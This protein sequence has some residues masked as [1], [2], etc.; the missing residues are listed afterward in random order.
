MSNFVVIVCNYNN[1]QFIEESLN[2][3]KNQS[4]TKWRAIIIDDFSS[5]NSVEI[6]NRSIKNDSRFLFLQNSLNIG[7]Q[8]SL[9]LALSFVNE[10][11]F[12]ARLDPDDTLDPEA[13]EISTKVHIE[14]PEVGLVYSDMFFCDEQLNVIDVH[15][16]KQIDSLDLNYYNFKGEISHF[17]SFKK[18]FFNLTSGIDPF[19]KRAEDKDIFMKMCE[20]APVRYVNKPLYF[21]RIHK[22]GASTFSNSEKA[23]FWHWVALIKMAERRNI[24]IEELF[25]DFYINRQ[26]YERSL[27]ALNM[28]QNNPLIKLL[29][30]LK[31]I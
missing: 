16:A 18:S 6:I 9:K 31:L 10:F 19:I 28:Y 30:K 2:S 23:Q 8:Q 4:N 27:S 21:Y 7:L 20:V 29:H 25:V 1:G 22:G 12:F 15:K 14:H 11:D 3:L 24:D 17:A 26:T 13:I 5:D